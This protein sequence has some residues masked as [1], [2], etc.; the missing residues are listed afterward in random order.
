LRPPAPVH[1]RAE[2]RSNGDVA[3]SWVR[4]SRIAWTW[5]SGSETPLGEERET[6][7]VTLASSEVTRSVEVDVPY[8]LYSRA[9]QITDGAD[10]AIE[11]QVAQFG[12]HGS[13]RPAAIHFNI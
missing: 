12:T 3:L 1:L 8:L 5:A 6:Y 2:R 10:G 9:D 11:L 13:S 4:R 7:R